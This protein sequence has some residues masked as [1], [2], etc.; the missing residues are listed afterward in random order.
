MRTRPRIRRGVAQ[1]R[2]LATGSLQT[3]EA[4]NG[5]GVTCGR[6]GTILFAPDTGTGLSRVSPDG[7]KP[8]V[9]TTLDPTAQD[10]SH[11]WPSFLPDGRHYL[12]LVRGGTAGKPGIYVGRLGSKGRRFVAEAV[13]AVQYSPPGILLYV[14]QKALVAQ[15]FDAGKLETVGPPFPLVAD[16]EALGDTQP[17]GYA[18]FSASTNGLLAVRSGVSSVSQLA[19]FDRQGKKLSTTGSASDQDEI[20]L[21]PDGRFVAFERNDPALGSSDVWRLD[22]ERGVESRITYDPGSESTAT[23]APDGRSI[24]YTSGDI[25]SLSTDMYQTNS[26]GTGEKRLLLHTTDGSLFPDAVSGDGKLLLY[27]HQTQKGSLDLM[28]L[29]LS[30]GNPTT[31]LATPFDEAH[32]QFSPDGRFVSYTSTESGREE[33]YVRPFPSGDEKWQVSTAGGDQAVWKG[34]GTEL[35]YLSAAQEIMAVPVEKKASGLSFGTPLKLFGVRVPAWGVTLSRCGFQASHDGTRFLVNEVTGGTDRSPITVA[36]NW[37]A[38][39]KK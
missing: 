15:P 17:T 3:L 13:S 23:W 36:L 8:V 39:I 9:E 2:D 33:I 10:G 20:S 6:D 4:T 12:Y 32:G 37:T 34:D 19:W 11:R 27:E 35:Y 21:S 1:A 24:V 28:L 38:D 16:M 25:V 18:R 7:G 29:P 22:L 14:R 31:Y 26:A 5:R 30:G